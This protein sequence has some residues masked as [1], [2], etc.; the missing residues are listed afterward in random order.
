MRQLTFEVEKSQPDIILSGFDIAANAAITLIG[1]HM[2]IPVAHIQGGEVTGTI[3][4][5]LRHSMT[6]FAHYHF[7]A[8]EDACERLKKMGER[9]DCIFMLAAHHRCNSRCGR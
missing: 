2:N 3:D 8:N 6:K 5:S 1:A 4:E 7:A 9:P